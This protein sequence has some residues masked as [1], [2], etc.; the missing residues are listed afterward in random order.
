M[1]D[2]CSVHIDLIAGWSDI[3]WRIDIEVGFS[4]SI[5]DRDSLAFAST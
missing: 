4:D 5:D 3:M 1:E 2:V